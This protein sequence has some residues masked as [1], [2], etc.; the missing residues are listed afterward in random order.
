MKVFLCAIFLFFSFSTYS[1]TF[2]GFELLK[3]KWSNERV[4]YSDLSVDFDSCTVMNRN[5]VVWGTCR[6]ISNNLIVIITKMSVH[7]FTRD[8]NGKIITMLL[9]DNSDMEVNNFWSTAVIGVEK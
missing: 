8:N 3:A 6:K 4:I 5:T 7:A 1:T 9:R 2:V